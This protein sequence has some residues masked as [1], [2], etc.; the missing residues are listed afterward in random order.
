MKN[1]EL[2]YLAGLVENVDHK[3]V[4][5]TPHAINICNKKSQQSITVDPSGQSLRV[6]S[7]PVYVG[8]KHGVDLFSVDYGDLEIIDNASKSPIGGLPNENDG[9]TYIVSGQ[10]LDAI[11]K[12]HPE[13]K[14]FVAPGDLLRD[15]KGQ[16]IGCMGLRV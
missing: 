10:C 16:P 5:L 2:L 1:K 11:K 13:R 15:E 3:F 6:S 8:E 4:N 14:D 9:V 7:K 12:K